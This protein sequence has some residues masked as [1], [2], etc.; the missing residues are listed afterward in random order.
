MFCE[1]GVT[2]LF[3]GGPDSKYFCLCGLSGLCCHYSALLLQWESS[4]RKCVNEW[5]WL[6]FNK[7]LCTQTDSWTTWL[8]SPVPVLRDG[9]TLP[10]HLRGHTWKNCSKMGLNGFYLLAVLTSQESY[11]SSLSL[12]FLICKLELRMPPLGLLWTSTITPTEDKM[13]GSRSLSNRRRT[14]GQGAGLSH[15]L[16]KS[17]HFINI[18]SMEA[19]FRKLLKNVAVRSPRGKL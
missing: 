7:T 3:F 4:Q 19:T 16:L 10:P 6:C 17:H 15:S 2:N 14:W 1:G 13:S 11:F 12:S 18:C 8:S 5:V 9:H